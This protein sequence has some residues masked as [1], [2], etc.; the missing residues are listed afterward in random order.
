MK[1]TLLTGKRCVVTGGL[2]F[3]G[4][5]VVLHLLAVGADVAVIDA[6]IPQHGGER[7][8]IPNEVELLVADIGAREVGGLL[9]GADVVFNIA[10]QVSHADSMADPL[11]DLDLNYRSHL[12]FLE[13]AASI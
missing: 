2:G 3:I 1:S 10:G 9:D 11:R 8:N 5:N 6:L 7:C 12:L 13:P 4:S